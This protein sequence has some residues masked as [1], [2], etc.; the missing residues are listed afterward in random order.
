RSPVPATSSLAVRMTD[1]A[2]G[3]EFPWG[4]AFL[5]DGRML[6][7][8][9]AGRVRVVA[10]G[11]QVG[12]PPAGVPPVLYDDQ[13]GL[14]DVALD[15]QFAKNRV[16]YLSYSEPGEGSGVAGTSVA[17][18]E[19]GAKGLQN[20]RVIYRQRPKLKGSAH[21]GSRIVFRRDGTMFVT[22]GERFDYR[23]QAQDLMSGLGKIVR[24]N[25]D[26]SVPRD[27]PLVGR[28]DA[29]PHI[30]SYGH[31]NVQG[32][33]LHPETGQLWTIEHGARGGDEL[34]HPEP[35][36]NY[37]WPIIAYGM[38]YNRT[39][40]GEGITA[41]AGMEQPVY[42]WD[43]VIAPSGLT[44][45]TGDKFPSF[46]GG[47]LI[48]SL[49]GGFVHLTLKD[50]RVAQ[51]RRYLQKEAGRTRYVLQGPDGF[52]YLLIDNQKGRIVRVSPEL[53]QHE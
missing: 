53:K 50:G 14:L 26:G 7:T 43:P 47:I 6:V 42:Y 41:K 49:R 20:L 5:P 37:G 9:R 28:K 45:Y 32:A 39:P 29:L 27:N 48:S 30:W 15:P 46:K 38:N 12:E 25:K 19:L 40:I 10:S 17:R 16:V 44:F 31:R 36:K 3:L 21:F 24:I 18:A 35:G 22:Q 33:A 8:E 23:D 1:V 2:T 52:L 13:G 34:N 4:L 11:S 51:E